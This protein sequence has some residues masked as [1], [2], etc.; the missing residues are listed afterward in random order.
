MERRTDET[1][2]DHLLNGLL[3]SV[4]WAEPLPFKPPFVV[5]DAVIV[6]QDGKK[7]QAVGRDYLAPFNHNFI[8]IRQ[9]GVDLKTAIDTDLAHFKLM[10]SILFACISTTGNHGQS[11]NLIENDHLKAFDYLVERRVRTAI[12]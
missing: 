2:T 7:G 6:D 8:N 10:E 9:A 11:G 1:K 12:S 3:A 4:I 5:K